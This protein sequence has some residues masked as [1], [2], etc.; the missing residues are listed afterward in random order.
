MMFKAIQLYLCVTL[1]GGS[2]SWS[3]NRPSDGLTRQQVLQSFTSA[4]FAAVY[5]PSLAHADVSDGNSLPKGA[6]QFSRV[7]RLKSDL[8]A[9]TKRLQ[10]NPQDIDKKE[11]DNIG[12]FLRTAYSTG[13]DMTDVAATAANK[14]TALKAVE[15]MR[16]YAQAGDVSVSKQD[17][18]G[19]VA[20]LT[21]MSGLVNDFFD[22]LSDVPDE[23]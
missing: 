16:K 20:I 21:K 17:A 5:A 12:K 23:L 3:A 8:V 6:A 4:S 15:Q 14:D 13:D 7:I 19:L 10:D 22:A 9:V 11:W 2:R 18:S 1:F